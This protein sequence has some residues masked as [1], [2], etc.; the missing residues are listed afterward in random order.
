VADTAR[1]ETPKSYDR[2]GRGWPDPVR[3]GPPGAA[4]TIGDPPIV[5][6]RPESPDPG[7][8]ADEFATTDGMLVT[9]VCQSLSWGFVVSVP[10]CAL[11]RMTTR[12]L[13]ERVDP[14]RPAVVF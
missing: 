14:V 11:A 8:V 2:V 1:D 7:R 5:R 6:R 13:G 12:P 4:R 3:S 9:H 10:P